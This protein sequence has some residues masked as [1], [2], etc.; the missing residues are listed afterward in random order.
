MGFLETTSPG[1]PRGEFI[2][3]F[4]STSFTPVND[5]TRLIITPSGELDMRYWPRLQ[6][7]HVKLTGPVNC[8]YG[9]VRPPANFK[10]V[11][12]NIVTAYVPLNFTIILDDVTRYGWPTGSRNA[13][14]YGNSDMEFGGI[15][16]LFSAV[17]VF[18]AS[19]RF[20]SFFVKC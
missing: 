17:Y 16:R 4:E 18:L 3:S 1:L 10:S 9:H 19:F 7:S 5:I 20:S 6:E 2:G 8:V 11:A 13:M 12:R 15:F 14:P